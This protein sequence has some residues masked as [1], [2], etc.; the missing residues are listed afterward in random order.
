VRTIHREGFDV[1]GLL[2][3]SVYHDGK[4]IGFDAVDLSSGTEA[5]LARCGDRAG[6]IGRFAF[7]DEG[8]QLGRAALDGP[9]AESADLV[10][11]DEFG[12]LE[13]DGKGWRENVD[14]VLAS[15]A[16]IV[17]LVVRRELVGRVRQLYAHFGVEV[18]D[19][20]ESQSAD[21]VV[22][23]LKDRRAVRGEVT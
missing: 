16:G 18:L 15:R 7:L 19:A 1:A 20:G 22:R 4:L 5:P 10:I 21:E 11:I 2:A 13:L 3:R 23:L 8:L 9:G 14:S 12:P 6:D 17:L